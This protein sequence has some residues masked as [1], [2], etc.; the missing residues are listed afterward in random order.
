MKSADSH[1][2]EI[3]LARP[4][5]LLIAVKA[6]CIFLLW[7]AFFSP[8]HRPDTSVDA[9]GQALFPSTHLNIDNSRDKS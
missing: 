3:K 2:R 9:V 1:G 4:L 6:A 7:L 8:S 5:W